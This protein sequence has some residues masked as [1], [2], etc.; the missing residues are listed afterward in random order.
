MRS[1]GTSTSVLGHA[2]IG[3]AKHEDARKRDDGFF[4]FE[5][6]VSIDLEEYEARRP[7]ESKGAGIHA[8][9]QNHHLRDRCPTH[10]L[11]HGIV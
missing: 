11:Q 6:V 1:S 5:H 3:S 2:A 4:V 8:R 9:S 10:R 7:V